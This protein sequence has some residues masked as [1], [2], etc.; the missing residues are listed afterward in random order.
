[1]EYSKPVTST[2]RYARWTRNSIYGVEIWMD[3]DFG[4][5]V[6]VVPAE[7]D[8]GGVTLLTKKTKHAQRPADHTHKVTFGGNKSTR[9]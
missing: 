9:K 1:M 3:A 2:T 8:K 5:A 4:Q 7:G 6:G